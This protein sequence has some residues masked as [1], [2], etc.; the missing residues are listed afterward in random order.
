MGKVTN[1]ILHNDQKINATDSLFDVQNRAFNY[2]DGIFESMRMINGQIPFLKQHLK[3]LIHGCKVLR[4]SPKFQLTEQSILDRV[5]S[6]SK[7]NKIFKS[8]RVKLVIYREV[9][10][11][12][13]PEQSQ[14]GYMLSL[15]RMDE[16]QFAL[17]KKGILLGV[18]PEPLI[19]P[20][21]LSSVKKL[22]GTPY[23]YAASY[24]KSQGWDDA[25]LVNAKMRVAESAG[26]NLF[27]L[28]DG[29]LATPPLSEGPLP[30]VM[31]E[32]VLSLA[33]ECGLEPIEAPLR[34]DQFELMD[35]IWLTNAVRGVQWV[36]GFGKKRF[37]STKAREM[38]EAINSS[39]LQED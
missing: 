7:S 10:G 12:Y 16:A 13:A 31:R 26:S 8:G 33:K 28:K 15:S 30:G 11:L 23:V 19:L 36:G 27:V 24:A 6:L 21:K 9:G 17:N 35:E 1:F 3:R 34:H 18:C 22:G 2:G 4:L 37:F 25:L 32:V 5:E 29:K 38:M 14:S 39:I 20:N